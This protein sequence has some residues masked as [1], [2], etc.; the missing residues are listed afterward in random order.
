MAARSSGGA[1]PL[2]FLSGSSRCISALQLGTKEDG[3]CQHGAPT[4]RARARGLRCRLRCAARR[5]E[6]ACGVRAGT[7]L[8]LSLTS[9]S[10]RLRLRLHPSLAH[11]GAARREYDALLAE[12]LL[13]ARADELD[14]RARDRVDP[15]LDHLPHH[16]RGGRAQ[17]RRC[18]QAMH[19]RCAPCVLS[20]CLPSRGG[21][22]EAHRSA[23][24]AWC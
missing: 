21:G 7:S 15:R 9:L 24:R 13:V 3:I 19:S 23:L 16:L 17:P 5:G 11:L 18:T 2:T 1:Y 14:L 20:V 22:L 10:L 4:L 12:G 8:S 6:M